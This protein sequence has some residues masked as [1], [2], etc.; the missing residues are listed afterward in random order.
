M[1]A[2]RWVVVLLASALVCTSWGL[3][4]RR[5]GLLSPPP[6]PKGVSPPKAQWYEQRLDHF[7]EEDKRMWKQRY[8]VNDTH[9][10]RKS[11]PV[12]LMIGG[13]GPANPIW[14]TTGDMMKNSAKYNALAVFLEHRWVRFK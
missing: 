4:L 14:L 7:N 3:R 11:G 5:T 10:N 1:A 8:F 6:L 13:E 2:A 12:F 9:W